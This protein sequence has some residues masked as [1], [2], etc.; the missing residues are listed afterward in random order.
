M[1]GRYACSVFPPGASPGLAGRST[2]LP[3][4]PRSGAHVPPAPLPPPPL[5]LPQSHIGVMPESKQLLPNDVLI[6]LCTYRTANITRGMTFYGLNPS[7]EVRCRGGGGRGGEG[8]GLEGADGGRGGAACGR[9]QTAKRTPAA[10]V[11]TRGAGRQQASKAACMV[12]PW[13][14]PQE[15]Y[16]A[17]A[18]LLQGGAMLPLPTC[19]CVPLAADLHPLNHHRRHRLA[20][21][22]LSPASRTHYPPIHLPSY[23]PD[24][25]CNLIL[26]G[27]KLV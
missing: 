22:Q 16:M 6:T 17:C 10:R 19:L 26:R 4:F 1:I 9:R 18:T 2:D 3:L 7:N 5:L 24:N 15:A 25:G 14:L 11:L 23:M 27:M 20:H 13:V 12:R 8:G 21:T